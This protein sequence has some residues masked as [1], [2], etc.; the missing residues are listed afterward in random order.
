MQIL[1]SPCRND[2][3][4][5]VY[6]FSGETVTAMFKDVSDLFD[7]SA[8]GDGEAVDAE[9]MQTALEINPIICAKRENG[10]LKV[11]LLNFIDISATEEEKFPHWTEV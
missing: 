10:V 5:I 2:N 4:K 6:S 7:F 8:L 11:E 9:N 3:E 1:Y